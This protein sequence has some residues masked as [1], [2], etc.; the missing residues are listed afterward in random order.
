V[1]QKVGVSEK[2]FFL[3]QK[4]MENHSVFKKKKP[5]HNKFPPTVPLFCYF[6]SPF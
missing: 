5:T 4:G 6:L 1:K 2:D 3:T